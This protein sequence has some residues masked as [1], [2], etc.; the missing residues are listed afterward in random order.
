MKRSLVYEQRHLPFFI[1]D[2]SQT[3]RHQSNVKINRSN[4]TE[5]FDN[6]PVCKKG[7]LHILLAFQWWNRI[8]GGTSSSWPICIA[9]QCLQIL[10]LLLPCL[11]LRWIARAPSFGRG[12]F[13]VTTKLSALFADINPSR[14]KKLECTLSSFKPNLLFVNVLTV[15][16]YS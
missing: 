2:T 7:D 12:I 9:L 3:S 10:E 14:K 13:V 1:I 16:I 4:I 6:K 5:T 15:K 11:I 8:A